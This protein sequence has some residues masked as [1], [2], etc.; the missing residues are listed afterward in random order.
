MQQPSVSRAIPVSI[1]GFI[2]G[3]LLTILIR[4]L[5]GMAEVWSPG[6]AIVSGT[7]N[8]AILFIWG[9]GAFDP[10]WSVIEEEGHDDH[11]ETA[12]AVVQETPEPK[13][14]DVLPAQP[15]A[16]GIGGFFA[17]LFP[18]T[19]SRSF[20]QIST[21][22]LAFLI[23]LA[24]GVAFGPR[25]IIVADPAGST[26]AIGF[27]EVQIGQTT[28]VVS[29]LALLVFFII[30]TMVSLVLAALA[31][32]YLFGFFHTGIK[33]EQVAAAT[34]G[35]GTA[36]LPSGASVSYVPARQRQPNG[37]AATFHRVLAYITAF[38]FIFFTLLFNLVIGV[39]ITLGIFG[40][41]GNAGVVSA[42]NALLVL[43]SLVVAFV[44]TRN[45]LRVSPLWSLGRII[46]FIVIFLI[47]Y[48]VF[49]YVAIGL[50]LPGNPNLVELS[51]LNALLFTVIIVAPQLLLNT[52]GIVA[53]WLLG[54][55][56][57]LPG[58]FQ[59]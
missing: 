31:L 57:G 26:A 22:L 48:V 1:I 14:S 13:A 55:V 40:L 56:G 18:N 16:G 8:A 5:Q 23:V 46:R 3:V 33:Q 44:L 4:S 54:I 19:F 10:R 12:L 37:F 41:G 47:L 11:E 38:I 21:I 35:G 15:R 59:K 28:Y 50:I 25:L 2:L 6:I 27:S 24:A 32:A 51:F 52:I 43:L 53:R 49:Y 45:W 20:W 34:A 7:I 30:V 36:A 58:V 9:I 17:H 29:H 39:G 42:T